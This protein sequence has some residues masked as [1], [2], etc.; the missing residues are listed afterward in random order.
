MFDHCLYFNLNKTTRLVNKIWDE[1]FAVAKLSPAHGYLLLAVGKSDEALSTKALRDLLH[2]D[3]ST[4]SR[5]IDV[6]ENKQ[7]IKRQA[8]S[9]DKRIKLIVLTKQGQLKFDELSKI[10]KTLFINI[11]E[12]LDQKEVEQMV[13]AC[14][15]MST[16]L[17]TIKEV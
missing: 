14:T 12:V 5:F 16:Q 3:L 10:G 4:V 17:L 6:L 8:A 7:L 13:S 15:D 11:R 1:A 2:L 9:E